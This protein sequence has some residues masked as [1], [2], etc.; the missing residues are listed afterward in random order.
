MDIECRIIQPD[1]TQR[2]V[3]ARARADHEPTR[4]S[5]TFVDIT[6]RKAAELELAERRRESAHLMRVSMLGGLSGS[7]AHEL[8]QP[9][10]AILS[11]AQAARLMMKGNEPDLGEIAAAL[12]D[13]IR[14]D[15]RA[16]EV[17]HRMRRLLKRGA[18][19]VEPVDCNDLVRSSVRLL[20]GELVVRQIRCL[21]ELSDELPPTAADPVQLQQVLLNLLMNAVEAMTEVARSPRV[22]AVQTIVANGEQIG[23]RITDSG[24]GLAP[25]HEERVFQPY[26]TTKENGLGLGLAIC[27]SIVK[28][29]GGTLRL[30]NNAAGGATATVLLPRT[31]AD[32]AG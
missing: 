13:I 16:G 12:D 25:G 22:I 31:F 4:I 15:H 8:T 17:I 32:L 14:E 28:S 27:A 24:V 20:H 19:K 29:H 18:A 1:G 6:A 30:E 9:L 26:F 7:I 5:G 10:A 2:W 11:N 23:I 21:C 3:R